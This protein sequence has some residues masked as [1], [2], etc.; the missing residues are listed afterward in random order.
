MERT[1]STLFRIL[2]RLLKKSI[3]NRSELIQP[4]SPSCTRE[5]SG[6]VFQKGER[7]DHVSAWDGGFDKSSSDG[8]GDVHEAFVVV[9]IADAV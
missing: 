5:P 3:I 7:V 1:Y 9:H 6:Y 4:P 2:I 8:F